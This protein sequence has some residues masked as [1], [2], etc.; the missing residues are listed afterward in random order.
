[1]KRASQVWLETDDPTTAKGAREGLCLQTSGISGLPP[2]MKTHCHGE[3][4]RIT[5][6]HRYYADHTFLVVPRGDEV[7]VFDAGEIGGAAC[8]GEQ[9]G[10][11]SRL[12][13]SIERG[14]LRVKASTEQLEWNDAKP[15]A[16]AC[17]HAQTD[18]AEYYYELGS[19]LAC[20]KYYVE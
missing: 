3:L 4:W 17:E 1:V 2:Q 8:P 16:E 6:D 20:E 9:S 12:E 7:I 15:V 5:T 18:V 14:V 19:G 13:A 11:L 10:S